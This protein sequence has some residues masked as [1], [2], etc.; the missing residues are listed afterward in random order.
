MFRIVDGPSIDQICMSI[1]RPMFSGMAP[2]KWK[3]KT[4]FYLLEASPII[5]SIFKWI[6]ASNVRP[7]SQMASVP[8]TVFCVLHTYLCSFMNLLNFTMG[9]GSEFFLQHLRF[10]YYIVVPRILS[11]SVCQTSTNSCCDKSSP[12]CSSL[13]RRWKL[14][15]CK[16]SFR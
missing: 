9:K 7:L 1:Q 14:T 15:V 13:R 5:V 11:G 3:L 2:Y 4:E 6:G 10:L 16:K 8:P 12:R